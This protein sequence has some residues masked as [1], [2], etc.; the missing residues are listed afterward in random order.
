MS[1]VHVAEVH[2]CGEVTM[3]AQQVVAEVEVSVDDHPPWGHGRQVTHD[4]LAAS[5]VVDETERAEI[6]ETGPKAGDARV[7]I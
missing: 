5:G 6:L 2:H 1:E 7:E 4:L 3:I